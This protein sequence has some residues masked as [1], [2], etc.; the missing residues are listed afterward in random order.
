MR[1]LWA[2]LLI[3]GAAL[4]AVFASFP[5]VLKNISTNGDFETR[6]QFTFQLSQREGS[7]VTLND[8]SAKDMAK[9]MEDR[10][11]KAGV[12]SYELSTSG[13][14]L[15]TVAFDADNDNVYNQITTYLSFSGSFALMNRNDDVIVGDDFLNGDAYLTNVSVNSFPTVIVP[16]SVKES[17][18]THYDDLIQW[19]RDNP[20]SS[21]NTNEDGEEEETKSYE[22]YLIYNYVEGDTYQTLIDRNLFNEK[23]LITL[24]NTSDD[25]LYYN[26]DKNSFSQICGYSDTN[27]NGSADPSEIKTA[28][29]QADFLVNLFSASA[30]DYDVKLIKG[31][32]SDTQVWVPAKVEAIYKYGD[33]QMTG[34]LVASLVAI[35][36]VAC[37]M[38]IVYRL[39]AISAV[40]TTILSTFFAFLFM[41]LTGLEFNLLAI[42]GLVSVALI[43][44]LSN[45]VY[46]NKLKDETYRGRTLKKANQEA[47]KKALL[48]I[49][50]IHVVSAVIGLLCFLLGGSAL[51]TFASILLLGSLISVL[52]STLG[53]NGMMWLATNTTKLTG[54]YEL[55]G[56]DSKNVPN[57]MAEEQQR[58]YGDYADKDLTK[59]SKLLSIIG[60]GLC[61]AGLLVTII[62]GAVNSGSLFNN[63]PSKVLGSE[64]LITNVIDTDKD[65][66]SP[67]TLN[68][69]EDFFANTKLYSKEE[70]ASDVK[71]DDTDTHKTLSSYV[72]KIDTFTYSTSKTDE[73]QT[74][75]YL[76]TYYEVALN[77]VLDGEALY[78]TVKDQAYTIDNKLTLNELFAQYFEEVDVSFYDAEIDNNNTISLK[79][80]ES[81]QTEQN[82][83]F[84][85]VALSLSIA[86]LVITLYLM[87][88]YRLSRALATLVFPFAL[89]LITIGLFVFGSVIG[90]ALP[91]TILVAAPII[92]LFFYSLFIMFASKEREMVLED[93]TK[94]NS[95]EH[96][97]ELSIRALGIAATPIKYAT[98]LFIFVSLIFMGFGPH[99][100]SFLYIALML[101]GFLGAVALTFIYVAFANILFKAFANVQIAK[102]KKTK[103]GNQQ[104]K[105]KSA[106]P[107][108][109]I[110]IGIND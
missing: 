17:A 57:H 105:Q 44:L 61:L 33:L 31:L 98:M 75:N 12:T 71:W 67:V 9:T 21:T 40:T 95:P 69:I 60:G 107:E 20:I 36:V 58:Y 25:T 16:I 53:L 32:T 14:D 83:D 1:R 37:I 64:I 101:G 86:I 62:Y 19:S 59:K 7:T 11:I 81:V 27:G 92:S 79:K 68:Y 56:I 65:Q 15:V 78:A 108:E 22:V 99:D 94:D 46:L 34:T 97:K 42:A 5:A 52:I 93:K 38:A 51:H 50:D 48:P 66:S 91:S 70:S 110:F 2:H 77:S 13:Q 100:S 82:V 35:I 10:L 73:G 85:A 84:G 55:F 26:S 72:S 90:A 63:A 45:V 88:R 41:I 109:A 24:D 6:R 18:K 104:P 49:I 29:S 89:S 47:S 96:R 87:I 74:F 54:K 30:L 3:A 23:I 8:N 43:T 76:S 80:M 102:P 4:V 39:G 106:E 103:K 28:F